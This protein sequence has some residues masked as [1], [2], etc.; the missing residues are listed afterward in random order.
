M[1]YHPESFTKEELEFYD[2]TLGLENNKNF[3][4]HIADPIKQKMKMNNFKGKVINFLKYGG[5]A[6]KNIRRHI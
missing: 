2:S 4:Y 5:K 1:Y 6:I 3:T